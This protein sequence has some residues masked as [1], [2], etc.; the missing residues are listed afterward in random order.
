MAAPFQI[1]FTDLDG[2]LLE[3]STYAFEGALPGIRALQSLRIPIVFC[4]S[5]T[6]AETIGLQESMGITDPFIVE[7]GGAIYFRPGQVEP[8]GLEVNARESWNRV[9]LGVPY[10]ALVTGINLR[11]FSEM[12]AAEV[13]ADCGLSLAAAMQSK[14]RE[15]DEP[16]VLLNERPEDLARI[17]QMAQGVGLSVSTGGRYHHLSGRSDKGRAVRLLCEFLRKNRGPLRSVGLGDSPNDLPML[18]AVDLPILVQRPNGTYSPDLAE[19]L[20]QAI[21]APGVGPEGWNAAVQALL[22]EEMGH[23]R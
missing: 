14:Q 21:H 20:P 9:N 4:T 7:N 18:Q 1:L 17:I 5:K 22:T 10:R 11:G 3:E 12:T 23:G 13:A 16:F 19:N 2:T 8:T 6:F 15:F